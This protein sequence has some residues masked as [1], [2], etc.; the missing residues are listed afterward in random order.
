MNPDDKEGSKK[1]FQEV[2]YAFDVLKDPKETEVRP[3]WS[4]F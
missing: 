4:K 2:Q 3:I 1:K